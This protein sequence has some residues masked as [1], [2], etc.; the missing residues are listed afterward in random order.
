MELLE[1]KTRMTSDIR[2]Y[3]FKLYTFTYTLASWR[4]VSQWYA[5]VNDLVHKFLYCIPVSTTLV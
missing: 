4:I 3:H 1:K 5:Q 2:K